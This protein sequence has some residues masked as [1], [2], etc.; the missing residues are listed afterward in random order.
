[1]ERSMNHSDW[2]GINRTEAAESQEMQRHM[3][4]SQRCWLRTRQAA[5]SGVFTYPNGDTL[6]ESIESTEGVQFQIGHNY[7]AHYPAGKYT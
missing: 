2:S 3:H 4:L 6:R 1:M 7:D 5:W